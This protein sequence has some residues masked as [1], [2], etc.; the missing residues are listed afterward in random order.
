MQ[1]D[2]QN[3][4]NTLKHSRKHSKRKHTRNPSIYTCTVTLLLNY[5]HEHFFCCCSSKRQKHTFSIRSMFITVYI[6]VNLLYSVLHLISDLPALKATKQLRSIYIP[7]R[8]SLLEQ[9]ELVNRL[10]TPDD[11]DVQLKSAV[12]WLTILCVEHSFICKSCTQKTCRSE[13]PLRRNKLIKA[14]NRLIRHAAL[15]S[16]FPHLCAAA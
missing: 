5:Y 6:C 7:K 12:L 8:E 9:S 13:L 4:R 1:C 15:C 10:S 14:L 3:H 2:V 16:L 11:C